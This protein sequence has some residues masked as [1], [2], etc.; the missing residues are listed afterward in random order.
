MTRPH[1]R[2]WVI[3]ST[4]VQPF[5]DWCCDQIDCHY[6]LSYCPSLPVIR[7][8]EQGS[9]WVLLGLAV[10]TVETKPSPREQIEQGSQRILPQ[11][12]SSWTGRWVLVAQG[13]IHMDA[14]GLLGCFY[15]EDTNAQI[16]VS[17]S[18]VLLA[19]I[20]FPE[21]NNSI[22]PRHLVYEMGISWYVPPRSRFAGISRLLP[23][24]ILD[25]TQ[26]RLMPRPLMPS[27]NQ[28]RPYEEV[29]ELLK[30]SLL[31]TLKRL[32]TLHQP[33]W[34][35][36]SAGY[37]SRLMLALCYQARLEV[38]P[39]TRISRRT[40]ISDRFLPPKLAQVCGYQHVMMRQEQTFPERQALVLDHNGNHVSLGDANPFIHGLRDSIT[41]ISFGGHGF[42]IASGFGRLFSLQE[43]FSDA[44]TGSRD[45]AQLFGEPLTST[46]TAGLQEWL[47]WVLEH[48][49]A[50]LDWRD[51]FYLE[52]RQ[53]GWLSAKEQL[54]DLTPLERFPILNAARTYALILGIPLEKRLG[55]LIQ[56]DLIRQ[57]APDLLRYPFNPKTQAIG[58]WQVSRLDWPDYG[59]AMLSKGLE[60]IKRVKQKVSRKLSQASK[61]PL[62]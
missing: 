41:G 35:G 16:W 26:N 3:G 28:S 55:S 54:Y 7:S 40:A 36:L 43:S 44:E 51:R 58:L 32:A 49:Q 46:A 15:G 8:Q 23:S 50:N 22:D 34:L 33:L 27:I 30:E 60:I 52:Q 61:S 5:P 25:L 18:P 47:N 19:R 11:M 57:V 56:V 6:W 17:S 48:P 20:L 29:I 10:E 31:T 37:D 21:G 53:A 62:F 1:R 12:Y 59:R 2:Q 42:A 14:S 45:L 4:P 24:Q 9:T 13:Q 38:T 39:F